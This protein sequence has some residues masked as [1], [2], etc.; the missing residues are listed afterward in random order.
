[1]FSLGKFGLT[2]DQAFARACW[3]ARAA[4][5]FGSIA[6]DVKSIRQP[7]TLRMEGRR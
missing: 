6:W 5:S 4:R 2:L 3:V 7:N 1:M